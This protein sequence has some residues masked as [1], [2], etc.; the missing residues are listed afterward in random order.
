[1]CIYF[2]VRKIHIFEC[3]W[4][5]V[6]VFKIGNIFLHAS[7]W[8][9]SGLSVRKNIWWHQIFGC[10][11]FIKIVHTFFSSETMR[12]FHSKSW[13]LFAWQSFWISLAPFSLGLH[14]QWLLRPVY[15]VLCLLCIC[16]YGILYLF[17]HTC[18]SS[19]YPTWYLLPTCAFVLDNDM[20]PCS[21]GGCSSSRKFNYLQWF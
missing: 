13:V 11:L 12:K 15:G 2:S 1:M 21:R 17:S 19:K 5:I 10:T 7:T 14:Y 16:F 20:Y 6:T 9:A 18:L 3:W 8:M 4:V